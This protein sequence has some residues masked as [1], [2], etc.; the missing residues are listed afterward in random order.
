MMA[1]EL[2]GQHIGETVTFPWEFKPSGVTAEVHGVLREVHH[3]GS[4]AVTLW[5]AGPTS[6]GDKFEFVITRG[7]LV[8]IE[9]EE[10]PL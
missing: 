2:S 3:D 10:S 1:E 6:A 5:L 7:L 4:N 9:S 8:A